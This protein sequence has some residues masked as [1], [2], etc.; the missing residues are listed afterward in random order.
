[1]PNVPFEKRVKGQTDSGRR[2]KLLAVLL[3]C[4]QNPETDFCF[5]AATAIIHKKVSGCQRS[6]G[7]IIGSGSMRPVPAGPVLAG[8]L[9]RRTPDRYMWFQY[10][11]GPVGRP[12][13]QCPGRPGRT[14]WQTGAAGCGETPWQVPPRRAG[15]EISV[16]RRFDGSPTP[17]RFWCE[18]SRRRRFSAFW[19]ISAV[20]GPAAPGPV[21]LRS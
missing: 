14:R 4:A 16:P 1:M 2:A 15:T 5:A 19:R 20:S 10:C 17:F 3:F 9:C 6:F 12:A 13:W 7:Q 21:Q 18:R 11:C 8:V